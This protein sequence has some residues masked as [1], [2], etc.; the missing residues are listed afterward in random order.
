MKSEKYIERRTGKN[1]L[2]FRVHYRNISQTFSEKEYGSQA[3]KK[4]VAFRNRLLVE[5]PDIP[6]MYYM[7]TEQVFEELFDFYA[8]RS[9]TERKYRLLFNKYM[10]KYR[11]IPIKKLKQADIVECLNQMVKAASD[12]TIERVL[13][14]WRK[15][16]YM[17][18]AKDYVK[19]DV[20]FALKPPKSHKISRPKEIT[21]VDKQQVAELASLFSDK[22]KGIYDR[23]MFP[24]IVWTLYY[25]GM[26]PCEALALDKADVHEDYIE[27]YKELGSDR[28]DHDVVRTCKTPTSVRQIPITEELRPYL[29]EAM[30]MNDYTVLFAT[31][32]GSHYNAT[33]L[34]DKM[35]K[36][37]E[38]HGYRFNMYALRHNFSTQLIVNGIDPRTHQEL[39]GHKNYTMS[40]NYARSTE[41][42]KREALKCL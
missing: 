23:R 42:R 4:A 40:V 32:T 9:E 18:I 22:I 37:A 21:L 16:F 35:H 5:E 38:K 29:E 39:M 19:K 7:T 12:N 28:V 3:Y 25:T 10:A 41:D 17:A 14:I 27:V 24:L 1:G 20:T 13:T 26:R 8:L 34:A 6:E 2:S 31:K 33:A 36:L 30:Q 11:T 15:M